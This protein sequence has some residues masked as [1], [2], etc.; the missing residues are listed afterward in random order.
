MI[1]SWQWS[2]P[3]NLL[4]LFEYLQIRLRRLLMKIVKECP[5]ISGDGGREYIQWKAM[6][7]PIQWKM[8]RLLCSLIFHNRKWANRWERKAIR[9]L[10]AN[11]DSCSISRKRRYTTTLAAR[12]ARKKWKITYQGVKA[13]QR[14][15]VA[16]PS[17]V[18]LSL[19]TSISDSI[20]WQ[21]LRLFSL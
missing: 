16:I 12:S 20:F 7:G 5:L 15:A 4:F 11:V 18:F 1:L 3:I 14:K 2:M 10:S 19:N 9:S 6:N 8:A 13:W 17:D 21:F